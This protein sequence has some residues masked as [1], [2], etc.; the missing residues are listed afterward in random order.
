VVFEILKCLQRLFIEIKLFLPVNANISW[1]IM[2]AAQYSETGHRYTFV[3]VNYRH[4]KGKI[5]VP[6]VLLK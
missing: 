2:L 1:L 5:G 3:L 6:P 4:F